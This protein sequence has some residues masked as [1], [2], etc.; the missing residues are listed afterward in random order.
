MLDIISQACTS[1]L[2]Y[3]DFF[4]LGALAEY[5]YEEGDRNPSFGQVVRT[6]EVAG[7]D[8]HV[9]ADLRAGVNRNLFR[10]LGESGCLDA[11]NH[12]QCYGHDLELKC[13]AT[14]R[15]AV[16]EVKVVY[17]GT[18]AKQYPVVALDREK[19]IH[20]KRPDTDVFQVVFFTQLPY[21]TYPVAQWYGQQKRWSSRSAYL[22]KPGI[23]RQY[24]YLRQYLTDEPTWPQGGPQIRYLNAP[25][26]RVP[27]KKLCEWFAQICKPFDAWR[28][29]PA[30]HLAEAAAGVAVWQ[31]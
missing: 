10:L 4:V 19:L 13:N 27:S 9:I 1:L 14:R 8:T 16:V 18:F 26:P 20:A 28:F 25:T 21:Y 30:T 31:Y 23:L 22:V 12:N 3:D 15:R 29:D 7:L 11:L 6:M 5:S 24:G 2:N 17:D